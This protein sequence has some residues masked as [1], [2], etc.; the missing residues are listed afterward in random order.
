MVDVCCALI[1][2]HNGKILVTQRSV[3]MR[4]PLKWE[5]P[6]GKIEEGETPQECLIREIQEEL[7]IVIEVIKEMP[8][9]IYD[10]GQLAIRLIPFQCVIIKGEI[11]LN[12]HAAF[13][14]CSP[15]ELLALDWAA[16]DIPVLQHYL[17]S[18]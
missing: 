1:T 10:D 5:F 15:D 8:P 3:V 7:N 16:A 11:C 2:G 13:L 18:L 17:K 12:E 14:W 9:N 4:L 6:G